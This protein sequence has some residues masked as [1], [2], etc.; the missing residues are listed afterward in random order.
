MRNVFEPS[1][2]NRPDCIVGRDEILAEVDRS[3]GARPGSRDRAVLITGQ[4]GMGKTA[5]LLEIESR[6]K[7]AGFVTSRAAANEHML[8]SLIERLQVNGRSIVDDKKHV[9][10]LSA[11]AFGFSFGLT[12]SDEVRDNYGFQTK[13][14]LLCD[15]LSECEKGVL[16]L[17]DEVH[18][19]SPEMRVLAD[20]YQQ[21][22]G[23]G[24]NIAICMAGLPSS[25]SDVLNDKVLTFLNRAKKL[26]LG[27][28][29]LRPIRQYYSKTFAEAGLAFE[30]GVLERA[31]TATD[32]FPYLLQLIGYYLV[33]DADE[34]APIDD[35]L[36][37]RVLADAR[38]DMADNVFRP[39]L[40]ELSAKDVAFLKAL[41]SVSD[42][43][44]IGR[45][46]AVANRLGR[47][48][49]YIQVYRKRLI[50]AGVIVSPRD[51]EL[52]FTVPRLRE[53]LIGD[54]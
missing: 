19:T 45:V 49:G 32:G 34:N 4:R 47:D 25:I 51:G 23:D 30:H 46:G 27:K 35:A 50:S 11:G 36:L 14:A 48:N 37:D 31:V 28:L 42:E 5:L 39:T 43:E 7:Q 17:V 20:A 16:L 9:R 52:E 40:A 53:Y 6:A 21:L 26:H 24:K 2:G 1:F 8:D 22:V 44:G 18:A 41:A 15:R 29:L 3:L 38:D 33:E 10:G 12:F 13:L 54:F